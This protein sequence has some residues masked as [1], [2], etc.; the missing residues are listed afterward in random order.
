[1]GRKALTNEQQFQDYCGTTFAAKMLNLSVGTVQ[2]LVEKNQLQAWKTMGGHRR[3]SMQSVKD[4][5]RR[6]QTGMASVQN[7]I[8]ILWI[9]NDAEAR[10]RLTLQL[11]RWNIQVHIEWAANPFE[12]LL[13]MP[14][15]ST[16]IIVYE[17]MSSDSNS[18]DWIRQMQSQ[19]RFKSLSFI[20]IADRLPSEE[21]KANHPIDKVLWVHK[22]ID[23]A[24]L[25]GYCD[26]LLASRSSG[27]HIS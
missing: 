27:M 19:P 4:Y 14:T 22:S 16:S 6:M 8:S 21:E 13:L 2:S 24:W 10:K 25:R 18:L 17:T 11:G 15:S 3:I 12:A 26:A 7:A 23:M 9:Q 5:Q 1:M 20:I